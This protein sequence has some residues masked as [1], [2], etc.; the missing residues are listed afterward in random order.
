M[1]NQE[2]LPSCQWCEEPFR[3]R[4]GV[5][6]QRFCCSAHRTAFWTAL[7]RRGKRAV[8]AGQIREGAPEGVCFSQAG[9]HPPAPGHLVGQSAPAVPPERLGEAAEGSPFTETWE[10]RVIVAEAVTAALVKAM[11]RIIAAA[12][13]SNTS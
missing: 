2:I 4:R 10:F 11:P 9:K 1:L 7:R 6:A 13:T 12:V 8:A 3:A 5:T